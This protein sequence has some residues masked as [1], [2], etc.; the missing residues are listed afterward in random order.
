MEIVDDMQAAETSSSI[1]ICTPA[2]VQTPPSHE[3]KQ[4]ENQLEGIGLVRDFVISVTSIQNIECHT[5]FLKAKICYKVGGDIV[6]ASC[7]LTLCAVWQFSL[8]LLLCT[9]SLLYQ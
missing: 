5:H 6:L 3:E 7:T 8:F 1:R 4:L 2:P 9:Q